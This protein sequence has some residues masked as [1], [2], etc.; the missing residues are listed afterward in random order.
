[1]Y[2][3]SRT[4]PPHKKAALSNFNPLT[5]ISS[6][7]KRITLIFLLLNRSYILANLKPS[8]LSG[9]RELKAQKKEK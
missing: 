5:L 6:Y 1:M 9:I 4:H 7:D 8:S 3:Y 2:R